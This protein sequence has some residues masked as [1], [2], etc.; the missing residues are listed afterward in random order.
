MKPLIITM[1]EPAGIGVEFCL[2]LLADNT[3]PPLVVIGDRHILQQRAKALHLKFNA[4]DYAPEKTAPRAVYH[5]PAAQA[6][7]AG[8]LQPANASHVLAQLQ[9]AADG[10]INGD[11][12]AMV[13]SPV[14][15]AS[16]LAAGF[17]FTGQT[18]Y[19][20]DHV[21]A[22]HPVMLLAAPDLRVALATTHLP[23][24]QVA[25]AISTEGLLKTLTVL[26]SNLPRYF[27][28][29]T[30]P[31]IVMCG[32]N[33]HA[34]ENGQLGD[35]E[36]RLLLPAIAQAQQQ[37]MNVEGPLSADTLL[38]TARVPDTDCILAMYHDQGLPA[39]KLHNF[40]GT[41]NITLGL[42]FLR[43]SPDH[44]VALDI[45]ASGGGDLSSMRT[46]VTFAAEAV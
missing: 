28:T 9:R 21:N 40:S 30:P 14:S 38:A 26:N 33:P 34:G 44:G 41:I 6:V 24:R 29:A 37:G 32:L 43:T 46:A 11:F 25:D 39:I 4:D 23:L 2:R 7:A 22:P 20:A 1:G 3:L 36:Q 10:C 31:R 27:A 19:I 17:K 13:T 42:P 18:E 35:E 8:D 5:V 12:S 45:A 16:I 15:K